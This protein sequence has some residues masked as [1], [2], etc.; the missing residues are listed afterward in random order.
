MIYKGKRIKAQTLNWGKGHYGVF[1]LMETDVEVE[2]SDY[3]HRWGYYITTFNSG[4]DTKA[5]KEGWFWRFFERT[6]HVSELCISEGAERES[7]SSQCSWKSLPKVWQDL[8]EPVL[9]AVKDGTFETEFDL[10]KLN[11]ER[12]AAARRKESV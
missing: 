9:D 11:S 3:Y 12:R 2:I 5:L 1:I 6:L 4:A 7:L 10:Q 8:L